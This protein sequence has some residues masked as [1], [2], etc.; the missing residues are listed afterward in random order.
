MFDGAI[1]PSHLPPLGR[2]LLRLVGGRYGDFVSWPRV[3][4]WVD[5][6]SRQLSE[7]TR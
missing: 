3:D 1:H 2:V 5:R 6:V 4:E 7:T